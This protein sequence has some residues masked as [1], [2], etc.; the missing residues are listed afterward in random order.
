MDTQTYWDDAQIDEYDAKL[1]QSDDLLFLANHYGS[2][3][4][5]L[6]Q[7]QHGYTKYYQR[8]FQSLRKRHLKILEIGIAR[9]SSLKT[10]AS[11][12][13]QAKI[14]GIDINRNCRSLCQEF[15]NVSILI[16]DA[17]SFDFGDR[18]YDIVIDDG[19][20][21]AGDIVDTWDNLQNHVHDETIYVIEDIHATADQNY[22]RAF[23]EK[24]RPDM[25]EEDWLKTH[26]FER[27][28]A[29]LMKLSQS[30]EVWS[31]EDKIAFIRKRGASGATGDQVSF[32][33]GENWL[34]FL[35]SVDEPAVTSAVRDIK[36]W[37]IEPRLQN[38]SVIDIGSGSGLSSLAFRV[39]GCRSIVS[40]DVDPNSVEATRAL[41][42]G[43]AEPID[44]WQILQ[45]SILDD[46]F[47]KT[48][49][50]FDIVYSWGVLHHT[51][52]MWRAIENAASLCRDGGLFWLAIYAGGHE[53]PT[54]LA[55][56]QEYN[57]SD[58]DGKL[59]MIDA[60][61]Q[62]RKDWAQLNGKNENE[63]NQSKSRGMN[64]RND[65]IDWLGGLPYEVARVSEILA[66]LQLQRFIPLRVL[67]EPEGACSVYL[68]EKLSPDTFV[69]YPNL[70]FRYECKWS[71]IAT[72]RTI[73]E[74][75]IREF[76]EADNLYLETRDQ[77]SKKV[78]D[79]RAKMIET[80]GQ[81]NSGTYLTRHVLRWGRRKLG[82]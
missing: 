57:S 25:K 78:N 32:S 27:I 77:L 24:R 82:L 43:R 74:Q 81:L 34:D 16:G 22:L 53:Y 33:F 76:Q 50:K 11:Y 23:L 12:F 45:A 40:I 20:H 66:F 79:V 49:P 72:M 65:I 13:T 62:Q 71:N 29:F 15:E 61:I 68:F 14:D 1:I 69:N 41:A 4:G 70:R 2:D 64:V 17:A 10:W 35:Q 28:A 44:S 54:D 42:E 37:I 39:A 67:E 5:T 21:L 73:M 6:F 56:K 26:G 46:E 48:L 3:K 58:K 36:D 80:E 7:P 59:A 9:G 31:H 63:W 55:L 75:I 18:V 38:A 19:S 30:H 60:A 8:Y 47:V 52:Q 51:G